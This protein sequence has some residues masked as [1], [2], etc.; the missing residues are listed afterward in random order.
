M[1]Q[2]R[3]RALVGDDLDDVLAHNNAEVPAVGE[4]DAERLAGLV[5]VAESALAAEVGGQL[6]GFVIALP[7]GT[8]YT[9][10]NYH[11]F[12]ERHDDFVYVDRVVVLPEGR[13]RGV[14]R[15]LYDA[16]VAAT[17]ATWLLAE[18]NVEPR[19]D[20]SLAFHD[21]YGFEP[22]EEA[23]PYG[24]TT[25]VVYLEKDLRAVGAQG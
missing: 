1:S 18:V 7:P 24:D 3:I 17:P 13:G 15:A 5:A 10:P 8:A 19:N 9:S 23:A 2:V 14:G 16:V 22:V 11:W 25:R 4:L 12:S 21:R 20:V 6:A